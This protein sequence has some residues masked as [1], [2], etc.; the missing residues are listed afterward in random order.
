MDAG[1]YSS[2]EAGLA[3]Y[4]IGGTSPIWSI[5]LDDEDEARQV[6]AIDDGVLVMVGRRVVRYE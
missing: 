6:T 5:T 4:E 3:Y 2:D 1:L